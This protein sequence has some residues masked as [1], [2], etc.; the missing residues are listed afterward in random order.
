MR[1]VF[2]RDPPKKSHIVA[3]KPDDSTVIT[4]C[5]H[6]FVEPIGQIVT[7]EYDPEKPLRERTYKPP[8][9]EGRCGNCPW[10]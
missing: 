2:Q 7:F 1:E 5:G 3:S 10:E 9:P 6:T 8:V 4:E